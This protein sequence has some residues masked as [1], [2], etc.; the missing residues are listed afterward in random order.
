MYFVGI[1]WSDLHHDVAV[2]DEKGHEL[3]YFT[4][5]HNRKGMD[6][7]KEKLLSRYRTG[8]LRL[9]ARNQK[10]SSGAVSVGSRLSGLSVQSEGCGL[11]AKALRGSD[12]I[13]ARLLANIGRSDLAQ[14]KRLKSDAELIAELKMLTRDQDSLIQE[15]TWL[16]NKLIA[17]LKE[18][19]PVALEFFSK[20]TLPVALEF[21]K[22][23]S[24]PGI[25]KR[26]Y[27]SQK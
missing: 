23:L 25:G 2:L 7:L 16:T 26:S 9:P 12:P 15:S 3:K 11:P 18:Y 8:K 10:R 4:I 21:Y 17:Y 5:P 24:H 1:D 14:L 20:P 19:Y 6:L 13:D 27:R 22:T